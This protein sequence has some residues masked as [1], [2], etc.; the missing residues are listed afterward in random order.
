[1]S[2]KC[3]GYRCASTE[4]IRAHLTPRSFGRHV[5]GESSPNLLVSR[6]RY[7]KA[8]PL[9]LYDPNILCESCD[10][11]LNTRYDDPGFEF[12]KNFSSSPKKIIANGADAYFEV[13]GVDCDFI[14]LF[15]LSI[16]WRYAISTLPDASEIQLGPYQ[17]RAREVLWGVTPLASFPEFQV[18]CQQYTKGP[19]N[20]EM[21]YSSPVKMRG[22]DFNSY[23]FS[24]LG[25][26]FLAKV[27]RRPF[28]SIYAPFVMNGS[29][30]L[31]GYFVDFHH[32][33]QGRGA[34]EMLAAAGTRRG[35]KKQR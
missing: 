7:T 27:D 15:V 30:L 11:Y 19:V 34:R 1:M 26:H 24:I 14:C 17:D 5:Q 9:G 4:L 8:L 29:Q 35:K 23:G 21:M 33:P 25:S 31:R 6:T 22:P 18:V 3:Q 2:N 16:L 20:A 10:G 32:T 12:L 28:P 13:E